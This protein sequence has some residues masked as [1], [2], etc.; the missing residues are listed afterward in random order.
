MLSS[1]FKLITGSPERREALPAGPVFMG[2]A[3]L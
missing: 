3:G 2:P 1:I